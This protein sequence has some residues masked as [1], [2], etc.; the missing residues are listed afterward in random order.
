MEAQLVGCDGQVHQLRGRPAMIAT[1]IA[2]EAERITR[3][4][5]ISVMFDC[6]G[7]SLMTTV[8]VRERV[9]PSLF[10]IRG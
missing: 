1:W 2:K 4:K 6:D 7:S 5:K 9:D 8:K 10:A 3:P